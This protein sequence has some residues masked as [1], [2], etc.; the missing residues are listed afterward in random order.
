M[1][2]LRVLRLWII[3]KIPHTEH[4][5]TNNLLNL[6]VSFIEAGRWGAPWGGFTSSLSTPIISSLVVNVCHGR[7]EGRAVNQERQ[8]LWM[9]LQGYS[10]SAQGCWAGNVAAMVWK[11][12]S[13]WATVSPSPLKRNDLFLVKAEFSA[14]LKTSGCV[15]QIWNKGE[16]LLVWPDFPRF[17]HSRLQADLHLLRVWDP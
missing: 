15:D 8:V 2:F 7:V 5:F 3:K 9:L 6:L 17:F 11:E 1:C 14:R 10:S 12:T 16:S 13:P 4:L